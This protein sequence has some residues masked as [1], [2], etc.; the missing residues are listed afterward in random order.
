MASVHIPR[1]ALSIKGIDAATV[2]AAL[3]ALPAALSREF[4]A[5][6]GDADGGGALR[7]ASAPS[8]DALAGG[9]ARRV[10]DAVRTAHTTTPGEA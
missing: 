10:A 4:A 1:L 6:A 5:A 8:A 2:S 7:F 9:V 3:D